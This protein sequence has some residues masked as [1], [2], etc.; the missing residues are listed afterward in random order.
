MFEGHVPTYI[1]QNI[2]LFDAKDC[3]LI[4]LPFAHWKHLIYSDHVH[5]CFILFDMNLPTKAYLYSFFS[6]CWLKIEV[7]LAQ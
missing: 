4:K 1:D 7:R 6:S 3:N 2:E 5:V